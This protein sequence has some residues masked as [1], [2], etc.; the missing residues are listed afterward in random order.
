MVWRIM[1]DK[2]YYRYISFTSSD[3]LDKLEYDGKLSQED[4][5]L[6]QDSLFGFDYSIT[7]DAEIT[8][9]FYHSFD[10]IE[11]L[12]KMT[13]VYDIKL[14]YSDH[15][16]KFNNCQSVGMRSLSDGDNILVEIKFV[17]KS[18]PGQRVEFEHI[19]MDD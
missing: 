5:R 15:I 17:C 2:I 9:K 11:L 16:I 14:M 18:K 12:T 13:A 4:V 3:L 19:K 1:N 7:S 10:I 8:I 6:L